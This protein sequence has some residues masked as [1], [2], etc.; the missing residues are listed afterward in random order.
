MIDLWQ[1]A[2]LGAVQG[3]TEFLP[4]SSSGHLIL[5]PKLFGWPDP[6]LTFDVALHMGTLLAVLGYYGQTW[7]QIL[8][9]KYGVFSKNIILMILVGSFP[10]AL[11]GA[12]G[13]SYIESNFRSETLIA[14]NLIVFGLVLFLADKKGKKTK[15]LPE[16]RL[17]D[18]VAVGLA[19]ALALIPGVSRSGITIS[20]GLWRGLNRADAA[21]FSF[22]LSTPIIAGAGIYKLRHLAGGG[23]SGSEFGL[24]LTGF[25][26]SAVVG[27]L[28]IKFLLS[29]IKR[30]GFD[31][32]VWYR[33]LLGISILALAA[34][35]I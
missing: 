17:P 25:I 4:I 33:V 29:Y 31:V 8:T 32:F 35:R 27:F 14:V 7:V 16:S 24:M 30:E 34:S 2:L 3:L 21:N 10:A 5:V 26:T 22:L 18:A 11:F 23:F 1:A 15:S 20:A 19:Q 6:G 12:L 9:G 13:E 28:S